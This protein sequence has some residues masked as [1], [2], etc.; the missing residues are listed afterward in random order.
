M[1]LIDLHFLLGSAQNCK[2]CTFLDNLRTITQEGNMGV[3]QMTPLFLFT[4]SDLTVCNIHFWFSKYSKF[5]FI[6]SLLW[7]KLV[8]KI[9]HLLA[10][11]YRFRQLNI[12]FLETRHPEVTENSPESNTH[13]FRLQ[14]MDYICKNKFLLD[15]NIRHSYETKLMQN[16]KYCRI[17]LIDKNFSRE[18]LFH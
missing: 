8:C 5:I 16:S 18:N 6:W 3:R 17:Y 10:K 12:L 1:P 15:K 13:F 14:V 2:K 11:S 9:P 7:S 4:F